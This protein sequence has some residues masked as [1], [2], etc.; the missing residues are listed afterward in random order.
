L[1]VGILSPCLPFECSLSHL[2]TLATDSE[3]TPKGSSS[4]NADHAISSA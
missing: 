4:G 1:A 3:T 2:G